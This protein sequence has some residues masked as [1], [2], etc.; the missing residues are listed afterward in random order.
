MP[1][2]ACLTSLSRKRRSSGCEAQLLRV[3]LGLSSMDQASDLVSKCLSAKNLD[4]S[5][6]GF[7][8]KSI[9]E[10]LNSPT[11]TDPGILLGVL[12]QIKVKDPEIMRTWSDV[13]GPVVREIRQ[14][15]EDR[16]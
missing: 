8:V 11:T 13:A 1:H 5:P 15:Q 9:E 3:Y 6:N 10:Y 7:V 14:S 12:K 2:G 16:G 4:L